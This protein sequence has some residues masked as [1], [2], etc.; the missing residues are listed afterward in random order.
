MQVRQIVGCMTGTSIDGIDAA[1][2]EVSGRGLAIHPRFVR[3]ASE[4][5]GT[6]SQRLRAL[7]DQAPF[8]AKQIAE[9]ARE[10]SL[11]HAPVVRRACHGVACDLVVAH[12]QTIFH[13]PPLSWQLL[14]PSLIAAALDAP[15]IFDLRQGDLAAGGQGAPISPLADYFLL[16][17]AERTRAIVNLGGFCNITRLPRASEHS[18]ADLH[19]IRGGDVCACNHVLDAV[20]RTA[21]GRPYDDGGQAALAGE[22]L[23]RPFAELEQAL[24]RQAQA[25]RSLGSGDELTGWLSA[26]A[27]QRPADLARTACEAVA[28]VVVEQFRDVDEVVIAGGGVHNAA[29][30][31]AMCQRLPMPLLQSDELGLPAEFREA[32]AMA[33]LGAL[34]EDGVPFTLP[35][36]SG[37]VQPVRVLASQTLPSGDRARRGDS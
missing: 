1:L 26:H 10:F 24:R 2:I 12:G 20:A 28:A 6:L 5:L 19:A 35:A 11:A 8:T 18:R 17:S 22:I 13:A 33:V 4:P 16:R 36:I 15:V 29:L 14:Q 21:L 30:T 25:G 27:G 34:A 9:L 3:G 23:S 7:A 37:A 31:R 32:A